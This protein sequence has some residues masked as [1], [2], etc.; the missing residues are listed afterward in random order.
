MAMDFGFTKWNRC[1]VI[2][3]EQQPE[4]FT[5]HMNSVHEIIF[6]RKCAWMGNSN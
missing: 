4:G 3:R 6:V 2:S 5:V 1:W